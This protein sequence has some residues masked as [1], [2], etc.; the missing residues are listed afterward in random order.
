MKKIVVTILACFACFVFGVT[1]AQDVPPTGLMP[2]LTQM[3]E[4]DISNLEHLENIGSHLLE[5]IRDLN[6]YTQ[7]AG[8]AY[9]LY[10]ADLLLD[11]NE[12]M[13]D[14]SVDAS[15]MMPT[16][17]QNNGECQTC[18]TGAY[19]E[20][21]FLRRQLGRLSC[22]YNNVKRFNE[23][24]LAFGDNT[25]GIHAVTGL[26]WQNAR[27]G[28]VETYD[29]FKQTY[30]AKYEGMMQGLQ[31]SLMDISRCEGQYGQ[32]D[33]YQRFGFIYFEMMKEKY[34]RTD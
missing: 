19:R 28:I 29:H 10:N 13:P 6:E 15:H 25:S 30:D 8:S 18:Y 14:L 26:S 12:C 7:A 11:N 33:W 1:Q 21:A 23:A 31:K 20:L 17:C 16:A 2:A 4:D 34:K 27:A 9:D 24:A 22:I 5:G 32:A 3:G